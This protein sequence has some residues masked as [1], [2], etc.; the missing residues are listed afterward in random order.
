MKEMQP[1]SIQISQNS[2]I[3]I[4]VAE[5]EQNNNEKKDTKTETYVNRKWYQQHSWQMKIEQ[6]KWRTVIN[7]LLYKHATIREKKRKKKQ[8]LEIGKWRRGNEVK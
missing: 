4:N 7:I 8:K 1:L 5:E 6:V 2:I 3:R